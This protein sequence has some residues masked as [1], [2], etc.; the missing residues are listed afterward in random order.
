[1]HKITRLDRY[2]CMIFVCVLQVHNISRSRPYLISQVFYCYVRYNFLCLL[3][4]VWADDC[5]L[6]TLQ[7]TCSISSYKKKTR[8]FCLFKL[9]MYCMRQCCWILVLFCLTLIKWI[10]DCYFS[11]RRSHKDCDKNKVM[12]CVLTK[13]HRQRELPAHKSK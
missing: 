13:C 3:V 7:Y 5:P 10:I 1:M 9:F 11:C 4:V 6:F 12:D 8:K 2:I